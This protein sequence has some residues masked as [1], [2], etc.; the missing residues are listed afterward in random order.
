MDWFAINDT[1]LRQFHMAGLV[2][3][4]G[5]AVLPVV[6]EIRGRKISY[7]SEAKKPTANIDYTAALEKEL[8]RNR[9]SDHIDLEDADIHELATHLNAAI[10]KQH[11]V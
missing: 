3:G 1:E 4:G 6:N 5:D 10:Q 9:L 2:A 7:T 11:C 8:K